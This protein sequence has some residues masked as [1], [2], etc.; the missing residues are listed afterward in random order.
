M[1]Q[2]KRIWSMGT[3]GLGQG[4]ASPVAE[5]NV[6]GDAEAYKVMLDSGIRITIVGLD[7]CGGAAMWTD[8]NFRELEK[9]NEIGRFVAASFA[10]IREFYAANGSAG[11]VMNCD[12]VAMMCV[13][14][15]DFIR[16]TLPCHGSCIIDRG[17]TYGQVIFYQKGFTYDVVKNDFDYNVTLVS[18]VKK[19]DYFPLYLKAIRS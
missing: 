19:E 11:A 12:P 4:N 5:F 9:T 16:Q 6:Y 7:M 10:K 13:V 14:Q 15:D 2:V 1:K 17:E 18:D 8:E 3:A